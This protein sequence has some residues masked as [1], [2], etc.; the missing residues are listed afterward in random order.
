MK[1]AQPSREILVPMRS[2]PIVTHRYSSLEDVPRAFAGA[3]RADD[4]VKAVVQ[5]A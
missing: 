4:Y 1:V 3:H 2:A 5:L